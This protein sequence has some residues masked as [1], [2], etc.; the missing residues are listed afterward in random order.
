MECSF[1]S[2]VESVGWCPGCGNF[3]IRNALI[4]ALEEQGISPCKVVIAAGIG[5]A[6][7]TPH[8]I[9]CN[10]INGLHGRALPVATA[11][12]VCN[13]KLS[14]IALGGDGDMY[15]EGGNHFIHCIRRNPDITHL[16]HNNMV[17]GLTK[18]QA[19]PT[20]QRGFRTSVQ[21]GGVTLEP[22]NPIAF[23]VAMNASFVARSYAGYHDHLKKTIIEA[24][25]HRGYSFIDILQ[26]CVSYN[27]L[28]GYEWFRENTFMLD[29][30]HDPLDREAAFRVATTSG[31][32]PLGVIYRSPD[33]K[34]FTG[35]QSAWKESDVPL[36]ERPLSEEKLRDRIGRL[37]YTAGGWQ[38]RRTE[39]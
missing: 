33:K 18:G 8:Y 29:E 37:G 36:G 4:D 17:Y 35:M 31:K 1:R 13:P 14:V 22:F 10:F 27:H 16:V 26:P 6:A 30:G 24:M 23:A 19:S 21:T 15:S 7:K 5:Q 9:R 2:G 38:E 32:L 3:G 34:T 12:S 39:P 20:S 11:I 28:N 25:E